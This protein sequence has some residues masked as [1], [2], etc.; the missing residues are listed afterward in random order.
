MP[1]VLLMR[2]MV[3]FR[4]F[5]RAPHKRFDNILY[6][7]L[8]PNID[9]LQ[10]SNIYVVFLDVVTRVESAGVKKLHLLKLDTKIPVL[11]QDVKRLPKTTF[12]LNTS[13][14]LF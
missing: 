12:F 2:R 11:A 8:L 14:K 13:V 1:P 6:P 5:C 4:R 7:S 10:D 3:S 9:L